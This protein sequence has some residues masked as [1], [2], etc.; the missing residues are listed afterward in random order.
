[1]GGGLSF[2]N[3]IQPKQIPVFSNTLMAGRIAAFL[4]LGNF[5]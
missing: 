1:M 3:C 5:G 2:D 4:E